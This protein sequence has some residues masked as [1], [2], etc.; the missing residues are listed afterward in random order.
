MLFGFVLSAVVGIAVLT[1]RVGEDSPT[2]I[3]FFIPI[4]D[5]L[6]FLNLKPATAA[7]AAVPAR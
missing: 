2:G 5:A 4:G 6:D 3:N 1:Y 7:P